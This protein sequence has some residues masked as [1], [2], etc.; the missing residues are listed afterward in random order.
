MAVPDARFVLR[1]AL[2]ASWERDRRVGGRRLAWRWTLFYCR[3]YWWGLALLALLL[4]GGLWWRFAAT[5]FTPAPA[6]PVPGE[7]RAAA[8]GDGAP[9]PVPV[10]SVPAVA[11]PMQPPASEPPPTLPSA[12]PPTVPSDPPLALMLDLNPPARPAR[13]AVRPQAAP[14][15]LTPLIIRPDDAL[16]SKE[17]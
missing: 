6:A 13:T 14:E 12:Q 7:F 2:M 4:A 15:F 16:H 9:Q 17:P 11:A 1:A 5:G 8:Q 10:V 3:K